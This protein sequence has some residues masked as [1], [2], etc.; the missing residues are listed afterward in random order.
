MDLSKPIQIIGFTT[1]LRQL[2][3]LHSCGLVQAHTDYWLHHRTEAA[4]LLHSCG[5][6]K[7]H[8]D[9]WLHHRTEAASLFTQL[10]TCPS[11]YR[12]LAS[13]QDRGSFIVYTAVDLSKPIQT[14]GF[15]TGLRQLHCLHSCGLVK[16][17]TD[18]WLHYRTEAA[19]LFTQLWT[20]QSS[21]SLLASPQD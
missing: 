21:Y 12:P 2:H 14:I 6:V 17:P 16:A 13:P 3:C 15:S 9:Y 8:T 7:A 20:C 19:A 5:L 11:P 18:Y 4:S 10:W 1:G